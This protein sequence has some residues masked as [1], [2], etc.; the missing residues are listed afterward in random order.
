[1]KKK[2]KYCIILYCYIGQTLTYSVVRLKVAALVISYA[3]RLTRPNFSTS[4][5]VMADETSLL[6][7]RRWVWRVRLAT[8]PTHQ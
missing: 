4:F 2:L 1:M 5:L 8:S 3:D 6:Q 7:M